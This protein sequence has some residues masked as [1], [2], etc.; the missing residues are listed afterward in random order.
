[1]P[2]NDGSEL[3][4]RDPRLHPPKKQIKAMVIFCAECCHKFLS[5]GKR[6]ICDRCDVKLEKELQDYKSGGSK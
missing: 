2:H 6:H 5:D 1:M 3:M 4:K